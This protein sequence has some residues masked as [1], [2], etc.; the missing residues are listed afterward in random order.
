MESDLSSSC[1]Q[2]QNPP[3]VFDNS[4]LMELQNI[5]SMDLGVLDAPDCAPQTSFSDSIPSQQSNSLSHNDNAMD[6]E[7]LDSDWLEV[8]TNNN[9]LISTASQQRSCS[10][11][12]SDPLLPSMGNNQEILDMFSLDDLDFKAP[13]DSNTLN[14]DRVDFAT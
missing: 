3:I 12:N 10:S 7:L 14:W 1:A 8:I 4:L 6:I 2:E 11:Y 13:T 9:P 5:E